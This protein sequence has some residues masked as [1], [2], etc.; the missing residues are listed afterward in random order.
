MLRRMENPERPLRVLYCTDT[1]P[2]QLNG[3]SVVTA[4]SVAG[5]RR[6][7]WDVAVVALLVSGAGPV[8]PFASEQVPTAE[9]RLITLPSCRFP[10]Y[11]DLRLSLP[12][13]RVVGRVLDE[14]QPDLV[15][16]ATEFVVGQLGHAMARQRGI[17]VVSSYHTDFSRYTAA[18]G[19]PWL[20][21]P[22]QRYLQRF[23]MRSRRVYTPGIP[24]RDELHALGITQAQLWGRGVDIELFHPDRRDPRLRHAYG[25][26][27]AFLFLHV[28]RLAA[29]KGVERIL[30]AFGAARA[31]MPAGRDMRLIVAG[32]GPRE[33]ALRALA[34]DGVSFLGNLD[35]ATMLP[36]LY[37]S[38]DAF[39]FSSHTETLGL[40]IL[41]A[42]ASGLPVIAAPAGGVADHL[43]DHE[44]GIAYPPGNVDAMATA[45]VAIATSLACA[46][47]SRS[48][49]VAPPRH[50]RGNARSTCSMPATAPYSRP[51]IGRCMASPRASR[52]I[53]RPPEPSSRVRQKTIAIIGFASRRS[54][55]TMKR[56]FPL[57]LLALTTAFVA[58]PAPTPPFFF[59]QMSDPQL[60]MFAADSNFTQDAANFEF[61]I[62]TANR[63]HPAFVIITGD[64]INKPGDKA[65]TA[66]YWR[67]A[68]K[69]NPAIPL[70][71]VAGNHDV[72]N[73][74][75]PA[76]VA[77]Y[78]KAFG[79]DHYV[80][81]HGDFTG[82]VLNS[83]VI[84]SSANVP[85][86]LA[87]QEAW[88][89]QQLEDARSAYGARRI[90][91]Y[92]SII[93]GS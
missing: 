49:R 25:C 1:Y 5:L 79:P 68:K 14:F 85:N 7:G 39:L 3:V 70:Y 63:L 76:S 69:L 56:L 28:G 61:A 82:I 18:Y 44:N 46:A 31:R 62:A 88:L 15:H 51:T 86:E 17:P 38:A 11:P 47:I 40:V 65:Q 90:S 64:L 13:R 89:V 81:H 80:F 52:I 75:T 29:E 43:R 92:S 10:L 59:I 36:Q 78:V 42:M 12:D 8:D 2:P 30:D 48:A 35:R 54:E 37:A 26:D 27:N 66:E 24:A 73:T 93:H 22:V 9:H 74:P 34:P 50:C 53:Q 55:D 4:L 23:H 41:E 32:T 91:W 6:R 19:V 67:I 21:Q 33:H 45:M 20:R 84:D 77:A 57:L 60:G 16:C 58:R 72:M 87:A 83:T 71:N